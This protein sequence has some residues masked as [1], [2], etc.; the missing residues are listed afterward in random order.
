M[1]E[2]QAIFRTH[3]TY[4]DG[5]I[6]VASNGRIGRYCFFPKRIVDHYAGELPDPLT[7]IDVGCGAAADHPLLLDFFRRR[8]VETLLIGVDVNH[9]L[10]HLV[11]EGRVTYPLEIDLQVDEKGKVSIDHRMCSFRSRRLASLPANLNQQFS[12]WDGE[13]V[14]HINEYTNKEAGRWMMKPKHRSRLNLACAD[15]TAFPLGDAVADVVIAENFFYF[16][17]RQGVSRRIRKELGRILK[18]SGLYLGD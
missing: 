2:E 4:K 10:L 8:G 13:D 6:D 5:T 15:A 3:K 9:E 11:K 16:D 7:I 14:L 12:R 17:T 18:P 1:I